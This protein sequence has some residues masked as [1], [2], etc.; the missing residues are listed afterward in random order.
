MSGSDA[1]ATES[2]AKQF[3]QELDDLISSIGIVYTQDE[4][5]I[6]ALSLTYED[7][8]NLDPREALIFNYKLHQYGLYIQSLQNRAENIKNWANH[9]INVV[10][11]MEGSSYG[12]KYT[13]WEE[14]KAMVCV[15]N[16]FAKAL[17][18]ILLKASSKSIELNMLSAKIEKI[19]FALYELSKRKEQNG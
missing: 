1:L 19:A 7:L 2:R 11:G 18:N 13:K 10:T 4:V 16:T 3:E 6:H 17:N 14:R 15:G 12:D 9:N 8:K 5:A